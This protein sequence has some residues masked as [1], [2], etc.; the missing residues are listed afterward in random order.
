MGERD[1]MGERQKETE[2][3]TGGSETNRE[4]RSVK[5]S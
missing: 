1:G 5:D 2:K 3:M 4:K